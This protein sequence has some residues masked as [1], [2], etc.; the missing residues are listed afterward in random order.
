MAQDNLSS[1][2]VVRRTKASSLRIKITSQEIYTP[3]IVVFFR[4]NTIK[5]WVNTDTVRFNWG[6]HSVNDSVKR[7]L[8]IPETKTLRRQQTQHFFFRRIQAAQRNL[9]NYFAT[10]WKQLQ[11]V[12]KKHTYTQDKRTVILNVFKKTRLTVRSRAVAS[13]DWSRA[14]ISWATTSLDFEQLP[15][16]QLNIAV[17]LVWARVF[18]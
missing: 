8:K 14:C 17:R 4:Q 7:N 13:Q 1:L 16:V 3:N 11:A 15:S 18:S 2:S 6:H 12:V 9:A 10:S 5:T